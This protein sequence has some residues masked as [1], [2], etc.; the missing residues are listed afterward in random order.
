MVTIM[1]MDVVTVKEIRIEPMKAPGTPER[2]GSL[3]LL[4]MGDGPGTFN[5]YGT[6]ANLLAFAREIVATLEAQEGEDG[7]Q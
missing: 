3:Y 1:T 4:M 5:V 7:V 2:P 6:K